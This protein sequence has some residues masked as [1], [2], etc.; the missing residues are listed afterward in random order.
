MA[1][2]E[3]RL[4]LHARPI[5]ASSSTRHVSADAAPSPEGIRASYEEVTTRFART[6]SDRWSKA[7]GAWDGLR[8]R[9]LSSNAAI[10]RGYCHAV[11]E[12]KSGETRHFPKI[13]FTFVYERLDDGWKISS[14]HESYDSSAV[15]IEAAPGDDPTENE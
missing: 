5:G 1:T 8:V 9:V 15:V 12:L 14:I 10:F 4:M 13:F 7:E 6:F 3:N 2:A 11:Y